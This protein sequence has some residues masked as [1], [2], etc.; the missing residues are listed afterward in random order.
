MRTPKHKPPKDFGKPFP[1]ITALTFHC[2]YAPYFFSPGLIKN[3][4]AITTTKLTKTNA[5]KSI[6][7]SFTNFPTD[8]YIIKKA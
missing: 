7:S 6:T 3:I 2:L 8:A 1:A 4:A 5:T